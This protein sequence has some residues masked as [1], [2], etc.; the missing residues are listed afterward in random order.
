MI[1]TL[2]L[3]VSVKSR[4]FRP[5]LVF[6][7]L[8]MALQK[9]AVQQCTQN[10]VDFGE[11]RKWYN[12]YLL[13]DVHIYNPKSVVDVMR[14]R[15]FQSY[16]TGIETYEALKAYIDLNFD[17]LREAVISM[18]GNAHCAVDPST[19]QND[20][21]TF[22]SKDDVL[23]LLIHLGYLTYDRQK[24]EAFIPNREIMQEF[25]RFVKVGGWDG[26]PSSALC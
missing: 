17:G 12:G 10:E 26:I 4:L 16:W 20:M 2:V 3:L 8:F 23:T 22:K 14:R 21:T 7:Q 25:F 6:W 11:L 18:L 19:S 1:W 13:N 15:E 9:K 5:F 24:K